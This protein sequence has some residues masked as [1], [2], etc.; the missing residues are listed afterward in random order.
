M[1]LPL[2]PFIAKKKY[3][4]E[5]LL[6]TAHC[7]CVKT[8]QF[9]HSAQNLATTIAGQQQALHLLLVKTTHSLSTVLSEVEDR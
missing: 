5:A 2:L 9:P 6:T 7:A 1:G 3:S 8:T 4:I